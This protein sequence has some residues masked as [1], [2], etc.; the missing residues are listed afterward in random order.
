LDS[1][2]NKIDVLRINKFKKGY[3]LYINECRRNMTKIMI[4][5]DEPDLR[6]MLNIMLYKEGFEIETAEDGLDF[7]NKIDD[8]YP[9][10]V[11][12]DVMMPGPT[13]S[14]ILEQ[15]KDKKCNPRII[16]L[17]VVRFSNEEKRRIINMG[18]V[19]DYVI[20]PFDIDELTEKIHKYKNQC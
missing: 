10:I 8:F 17:T 7:L 18:N 11:T 15:L 20:K 3:M 13:T 19:V 9:D 1:R 12:L 6:K 14:E 5:D 4:V 2:F 16:L